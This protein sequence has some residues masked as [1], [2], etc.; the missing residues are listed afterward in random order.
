MPKTELELGGS[1][2]P[3][4]FRADPPAHPANASK[5]GSCFLSNF[6]PSSCPL[7]SLFLFW[8]VPSQDMGTLPSV[9]QL[10]SLPDGW[11]GR[12]LQSQL[13]FSS[14][15]TVLSS[16][17][18]FCSGSFTLKPS[19]GQFT[20]LSYSKN[21]HILL[22]NN[23]YLILHRWDI[24][25]KCDSIHRFSFSLWSLCVDHPPHLH[26]QNSFFFSSPPTNWFLLVPLFCGTI[27]IILLGSL[28]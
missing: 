19:R 14:I 27:F 11:D 8:A 16:Q 2:V 3:S 15:P 1:A 12:A 23:N 21:C 10:V 24:N 26:P 22:K 4:A 13:C 20:I 9:S 25:H 7:N 18:Y 28:K 17:Q 6:Q 5:P